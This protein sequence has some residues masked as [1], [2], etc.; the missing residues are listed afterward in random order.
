MMKKRKANKT[1]P[2]HKASKSVAKK[3]YALKHKDFLSLLSK[4]KQRKRRNGLIDYGDNSQIHAVSECISNI[5]S[6]AVPVNKSQLKKLKKHRHQLRQLAMSRFPV[7][8]KKLYLK[9]QS[10]G[11]LLASILPLAINALSGIFG[12]LFKK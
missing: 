4:T 3:S 10:G 5:L 2:S 11:A 6:G 12:G 1:T 7:K 9:S 8:K